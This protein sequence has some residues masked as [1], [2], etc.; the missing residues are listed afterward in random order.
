M[1]K[2]KYYIAIAAILFSLNSFG[3]EYYTNISYDISIPMGNTKDFIQ[4]TSFRGWSFSAGRF[5][6]DNLDINLRFSWHTFYE[7]MPYDSYTEGAR[8][9]TGKQFRY[10]N[11]FPITVGTRY[12]FKPGN[13]I[14]PYIGAGLGTYSQTV[15][16]DMGIYYSET[17]KWH[18]GFYPEVGMFWNFSYGTGVYINARYD[19]SLKAGNVEGNSYLSFS[20]GFKFGT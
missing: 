14:S 5:V 2:I 1:K 7:E 17:N 15:R 20:V 10:I 11:S 3:Q 9:V 12:H 16:T 6:T 8:T 4:K 19:Y 18:F 13:P